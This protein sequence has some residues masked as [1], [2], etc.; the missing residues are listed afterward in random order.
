LKAAL[1]M[2]GKKKWIG[3]ASE[4]KKGRKKSVDVEPPSAQREAKELI[5]SREGQKDKL[6][7]SLR[8]PRGCAEQVG[9]LYN[10]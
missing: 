1:E 3:E 7:G 8:M 10:L 4:G 9:R 5:R 2:K 6:G